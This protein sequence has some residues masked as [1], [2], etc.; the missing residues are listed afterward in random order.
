MTLILPQIGVLKQ[1][2]GPRVTLNESGLNTNDNLT[3]YTVSVNAG[4]GG[5]VV[6][7]FGADERNVVD[8][9][10]V[11]SVTIDGITA[12]VISSPCD[13]IDKSLVG[14]A[15]AD[16]VSAGTVTAVIT[17]DER[18]NDM[19]WAT[20]TITGATSATPHDTGVTTGGPAT[21][22]TVTID[23]PAGGVQIAAADWRYASAGNNIDW[24]NATEDWSS[25]VYS[26]QTSSASDDRLSVETGRVITATAGTS[27][28][29]GIIAASW[30]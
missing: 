19:T 25:G 7:V 15:W 12:S 27:V 6:L 9:L 14:M 23:I 13:A 21:T 20:Y 28:K 17:F 16:G 1:E 11:V 24:T 29:Y 4:V 26:R 30:S 5:L 18:G 8:I 22:D 3:V 10:N 2:A